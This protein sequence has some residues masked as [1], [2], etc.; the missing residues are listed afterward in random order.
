VRILLAKSY[1]G[2]EATEAM[3]TSGDHLALSLRLKGNDRVKGALASTSSRKLM[4]RRTLVWRSL[5]WCDKAKGK[6]AD[7]A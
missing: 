6:E 2:I 5:R 7:N 3:M 1:S 4:P